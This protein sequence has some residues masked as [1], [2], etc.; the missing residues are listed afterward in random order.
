MFFVETRW[1]F[2]NELVQSWTLVSVGCSTPCIKL[3]GG[4]CPFDLKE[5]GTSCAAGSSGLAMAVRSSVQWTNGWARAFTL[6][7]ALVFARCEGY[8]RWKEVQR[9]HNYFVCTLQCRW[10][11]VTHLVQG[12]PKH[13]LGLYKQNVNIAVLV[14]NWV[15]EPSKSRRHLMEQAILLSSTQQPCLWGCGLRS[16]RSEFCPTAWCPKGV[17]GVQVWKSAVPVPP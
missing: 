3:R 1:V 5:H 4:S 10:H 11:N 6:Q 14:L 7:N 15:L 13:L 17:S 16:K 12:C 9:S 8:K 2:S